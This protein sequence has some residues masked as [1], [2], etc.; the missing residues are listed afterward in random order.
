MIQSCRF[1]T[2]NSNTS[3]FNTRTHTHTQTTVHAK[4]WLHSLKTSVRM[5]LAESRSL[6]HT[7]TNIHTH[8]WHQK[9][10]GIKRY[11]KHT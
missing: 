8:K 10:R 2:L 3:V 11:H 7:R 5:F 1:V 4:Q 9:Y 6:S